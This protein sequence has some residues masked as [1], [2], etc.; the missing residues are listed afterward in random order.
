[1]RCPSCGSQNI[2]LMTI[3]TNAAQIAAIGDGAPIAG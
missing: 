2:L 3:K 1:M